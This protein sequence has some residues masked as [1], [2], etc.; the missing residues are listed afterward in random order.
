MIKMGR[1]YICAHFGDYFASHDTR[2][3]HIVLEGLSHC[4][5]SCFPTD[6]IGCMVC[7]AGRGFLYAF[8]AVAFFIPFLQCHNR[9]TASWPEVKRNF[10]LELSRSGVATAR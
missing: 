8:K 10:T 2:L 7:L 1:S 4:R 3:Q 9:V 5:L 6:L